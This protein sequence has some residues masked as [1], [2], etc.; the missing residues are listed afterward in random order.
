MKKT[1]L[2]SIAGASML[3]SGI[4]YAAS[5]GAVDEPIKLA[6]NEWTGQHI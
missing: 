3:A 6:V 5:M 2:S 4:G 1:L